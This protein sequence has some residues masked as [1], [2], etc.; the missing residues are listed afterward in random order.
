PP[1]PQAPRSPAVPDPP[2]SCRIA[3][4]WLTPCLPH[5]P[6]PMT[7]TLYTTGHANASASR[8]LSIL[9]MLVTSRQ[10]G[11]SRQGRACYL[12]RA[13]RDVQQVRQT[14]SDVRAHIGDVQRGVSGWSYTSWHVFAHNP[15]WT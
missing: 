8:P 11:G 13:G 6:R 4:S 2:R 14:L 1:L 5:L 12:F 10:T 9:R 3:S 7:T 15:L